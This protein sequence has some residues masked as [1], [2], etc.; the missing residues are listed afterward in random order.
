MFLSDSMTKIFFSIYTV[1][2]CYNSAVQISTFQS[3]AH[4][5]FLQQPRIKVMY[6]SHGGGMKD[7]SLRYN[8]NK[9]KSRC[10]SNAILYVKLTNAIAK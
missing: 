3:T 10:R 2:R 9:S 1:C 7:L 8:T 4:H 5:H 6:V